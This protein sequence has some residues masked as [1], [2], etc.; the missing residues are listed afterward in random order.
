MQLYHD[1]MAR[2]AS[3]PEDTPSKSA[4]TWLEGPFHSGVGWFRRRF[5]QPRDAQSRVSTF[6]HVCCASCTTPQNHT[7]ILAGE[8]RT[9]QPFL[10]LHMPPYRHAREST[11]AKAS[12]GTIPSLSV[13][14]VN[15]NRA[16]IKEFKALFRAKCHEAILECYHAHNRKGGTI[17]PMQTG[18]ARCT[19]HVPS[20]WRFMP[21]SQRPPNAP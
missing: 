10:F 8:M 21:T 5:F 4:G 2:C 17:V 20:F 14:D 13:A 7:R 11:Y 3:R 19:S 1:L 18:G 9:C 16:E 12:L 15:K 6:Y